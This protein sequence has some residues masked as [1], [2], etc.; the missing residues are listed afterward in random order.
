MRRFRISYLPLEVN[1]LVLP[2]ANNSGEIHGL[3]QEKVQDKPRPKFSCF[4]R[5]S[6]LTTWYPLADWAGRVIRA[7]KRGSIPESLPPI[8]ER[9]HMPPDMWLE[10]VQEASHR[11]SIAKGMIDV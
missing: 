10:A 5:L 6:A 9:I 8:L 11:Y 4:S 7:D 3:N 2:Q 1:K